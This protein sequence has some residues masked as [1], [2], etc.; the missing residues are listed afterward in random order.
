MVKFYFPEHKHCRWNWS[1][2]KCSTQ[3]NSYRENIL[4][5]NKPFHSNSFEH[6]VQQYYWQ[7]L[8]LQA[9][10]LT[11]TSKLHNSHAWECASHQ[12]GGRGCLFV[13]KHDIFFL[14]TLWNGLAESRHVNTKVSV[15]FVV[16]LQNVK[17][18]IFKI[19]TF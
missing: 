13:R 14:G 2:K 19:L 8:Y 12:Q 11:G 7:E 10:G 16:A 17:H 9:A 18:C 6:Q 5:E 3:P 4:I 15:F 1:D